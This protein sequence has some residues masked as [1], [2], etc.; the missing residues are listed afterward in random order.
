MPSELIPAP[1]METDDVSKVYPRE[2]LLES[3]QWSA[4]HV[5]ELA[6]TEDTKSLLPRNKSQFLK[7]K[8]RDVKQG[9]SWVDD[10]KHG[11]CVSL[12]DV[13]QALG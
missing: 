6:K 11:L 9:R 13:V 7:S 8:I 3:S 2:S 4:I 10:K 5:S 1:D 12:D